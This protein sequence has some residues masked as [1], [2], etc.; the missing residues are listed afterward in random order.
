[1]LGQQAQVGLDHDGDVPYVHALEGFPA[2]VVENDVEVQGGRIGEVP[3]A[4][5]P[6]V[7]AA[8]GPVHL[9]DPGLGDL[10]GAELYVVSVIGHLN[11]DALDL[12]DDLLERVLDEIIVAVQMLLDKTL[13]VEKGLQYF[14]IIL[15]RD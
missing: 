10:D 7:D 4:G 2:L 6:G 13:F 3:D 1:M 11:L 9:D 8:D 15:F 12:V 5:L 14:P